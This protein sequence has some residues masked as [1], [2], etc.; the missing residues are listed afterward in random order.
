M[1]PMAVKAASDIPTM[2]RPKTFWKML[3]ATA[4][5]TPAAST[6]S[7]T[8]VLSAYGCGIAPYDAGEAIGA[9]YGP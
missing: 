8:G 3:A 6:S 2:T 7:E 1:V 9:T 5:L 4:T